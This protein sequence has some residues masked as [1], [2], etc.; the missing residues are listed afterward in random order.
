[1]LRAFACALLFLTRVPLP[2]LEL[3]ARD[4]ARSAAFFAWI[5]GLF[6]LCGWGCSLL[7]PH[8]GVRT[9]ALLAVLS[10]VALSGGLH[11]D[12][13]ADTVDGFSGGRGE[14]ARVLE[15]MRDSR[16]GAHGALALVLL[17]G[18]KWTALER[19][20]EL[21]G[22][23]WLM[24]P[25]AARFAC[26]LLLAWFPYA[27]EQGLGSAFAEAVHWPSLV[28]GALAVSLA[29]F[30]LGPGA[31]HAALWA[32]ASAL[33]LAWLAQRRLGGLTGDVYGATIELAE[34]AA[35]LAAS[36]R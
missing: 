23:A 1:M 6:A 31:P 35:L 33:G 10:W 11:L 17:I 18:L 25:I 26:T 27:R 16:I 28:S 22:H 7:T 12:G 34:L 8:F 2:K 3:D 29:G 13:L 30:A 4:M 15:I 9:A 36:A 5:G 24:A 21:H 14:R 19:A 20:L 32:V